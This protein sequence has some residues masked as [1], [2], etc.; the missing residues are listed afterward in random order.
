MSTKSAS[1]RNSKGA[2]PVAMTEDDD[3]MPHYD[4]DYSKAKPNRFAE[5]PK[6]IIGPVHG[7]SRQGA[8][9]KPAPEPLVAKRVYLYRRHVKILQKIDKN[10][11]AAIRSLV[12]AHR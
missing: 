1:R 9:R 6:V 3:L 12:D 4:I 10:L 2:I 5:R 7:G 8:G 11:S